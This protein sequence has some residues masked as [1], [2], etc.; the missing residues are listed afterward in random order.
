M[1]VAM[2]EGTAEMGAEGTE[3]AAMGQELEMRQETAETAEMA[4][5][6]AARLAPSALPAIRV[7]LAIM[8]MRLRPIR[9]LTRPQRMPPYHRLLLARQ[10]T[11]LRTRRTLDLVRVATRPRLPE[12][13]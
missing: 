6:R 13:F 7:I 9:R 11:S 8:M 2:E 5:V 1:G 10:R 4:T 12:M 3:L